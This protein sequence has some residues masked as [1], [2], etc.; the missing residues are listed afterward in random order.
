MYGELITTYGYQ[1]GESEKSLTCTNYYTNEEITIPLDP[2]MSP[3]DNAKKY[4]EKYNKLK[5]TAI[6][7]ESIIL[8]TEQEIKHLESIANAMDIASSEDDLK[9]IKE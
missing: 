9:E 4:F 1:L 5:R 2:L 7:L 3:M 8:E 6:A